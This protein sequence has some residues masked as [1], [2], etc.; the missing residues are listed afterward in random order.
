MIENRM[1]FYYAAVLA[2]L[3]FFVSAFLMGNALSLFSIATFAYRTAVA[4]VAIIASVSVL[5]VL[6]YRK[7]RVISFYFGIFQAITFFLLSIIS[8]PGPLF[9]PFLL[10]LVLEVLA[11][12]LISGEI[13]GSALRSSVA[14]ISLAVMIY[15]GDLFQFAYNRPDTGFIVASTESVFVVLGQNIP[16]LEYNG[17]FVFTHHFDLILSIQ[18]YIM[19]MVLAILISEN[20]FQIIRYVSAHG[21]KAGRASVIVYG[22]TGA[23]SC[24]C[25]SYISFLPAL[26][27]LLINYVL[28]PVI[29]FS[30]LLLI[31]T[32]LIVSRRY[33][34]GLA[35]PL[36]SSSS[37]RN[38]KLLILLTGFVILMGTP[39]FI[40]IVVYLSLLR[41]ALF[42][43]LTGMI[44]ILDGF[45]IMVLISMIF[46][47]PRTGR[48]V[49]T[50]LVAGG[51]LFSLVWFYPYLTGLAFEYPPYF[52]L[53]NL[54]MLASGILYGYVHSSLDTRWR[55]V[56]KEYIST[57]YGI[58]SLV[59][60]Y[61]MGTFQVSIWPFF[62][63]ESQIDFSLITWTIMLPV[64][65]VTTQVSLNRLAP[66]T[67][68]VPAP[69]FYG[70]DAVPNRAD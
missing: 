36:F 59:I 33:S 52:V 60:F 69:E 30:I 9:A 16:F 58:F 20:Y 34:R 68:S 17:L 63:I 32:Y 4:M 15:L 28:F 11:L 55:D 50:I 21:R 2:S 42:F 8:F 35:V 67:G 18:Q 1:K 26:S 3:F 64:M 40:T 41:N 45:V 62:T 49:S 57:L 10:A 54:S 19:F 47:F 14:V 27:I 38:R 44:M 7:F 48:L 24:Q 23:L 29:I 6:V 70:R 66:G 22:L 46:P 53:M 31:G 61:V 13:E 39:F 5:Q 12:L 37:Y 43:F 25:E 51:T 65:W 56:L